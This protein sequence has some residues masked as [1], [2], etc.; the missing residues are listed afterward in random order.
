MSETAYDK[1]VSR[2]TREDEIEKGEI[3]DLLGTTCPYK[4][5]DDCPISKG[6]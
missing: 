1:W 5:C 2:D 4:S 6:A 3:C